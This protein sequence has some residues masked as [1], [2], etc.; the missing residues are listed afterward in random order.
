MGGLA[1]VA[2]TLRVRTATRQSKAHTKLITIAQTA[3]FLLGKS[4]KA[5]SNTRCC[6]AFLALISANARG[7]FTHGA[8]ACRVVLTAKSSISKKSWST[9]TSNQCHP[10]KATRPL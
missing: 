7:Y 2:Y 5:C 8:S 9:F 6:C 4:F 1:F 3:S 10:T